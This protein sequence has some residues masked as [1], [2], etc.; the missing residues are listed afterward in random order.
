MTKPGRPFSDEPI[1]DLLADVLAGGME[2]RSLGRDYLLELAARVERVLALAK[3]RWR[4]IGM[5]DPEELMRLLDG[6]ER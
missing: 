5:I 1:R 4:A 3:E 2:D 6:E